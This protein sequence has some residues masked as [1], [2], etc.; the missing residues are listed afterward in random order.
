MLRIRPAV[1][2]DAPVLG[3]IMAVS[4]WS[5][6]DTIVSRETLE[7]CA[8]EDQCAGLMESLINAGQMGILLAERDGVPLGLLVWSDGE[9][10]TSAEIQ[11]IHSLPES[12]GTGLGAALI[13]QALTD[14]AQAG[15]SHIY[16]WAFEENHRARRFY[17]K[18]GFV[19]D[20]GLRVS[21]F[22]GAREVR[23]SKE[24]TKYGPHT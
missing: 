8:R 20:G 7:T 15:K 9:G 19:H 16:L 13:K 23:Y 22:D 3:R 10:E 18:Q 6:F 21:E 2:E 12:W 4:F 17:E 14:M 24:V 5:A 1:R 11:A